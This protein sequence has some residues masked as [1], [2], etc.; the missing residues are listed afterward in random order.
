MGSL[1]ASNAFE[2]TKVHLFSLCKVILFT[3][4]E[5]DGIALR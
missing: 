1:R 3:L 5:V 2:F 4:G